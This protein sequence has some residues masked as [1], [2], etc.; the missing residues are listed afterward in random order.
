M[1]WH[2]EYGEVEP[3]S[4]KIMWKMISSNERS[5]VTRFGDL[6]TNIPDGAYVVTLQGDYGTECRAASEM[7][8]VRVPRLFHMLHITGKW[9]LQR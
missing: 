2:E 9:G 4:S 6:S 3:G 5:G 7:F 8:T 1:S